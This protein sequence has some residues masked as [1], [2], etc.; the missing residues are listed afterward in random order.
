MAQSLDD[1][2]M[3]AGLVTQS[4]DDVTSSV[5]GGETVAPEVRVMERRKSQREGAAA[6]REVGG[7]KSFVV[8]KD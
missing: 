1:V 8:W 7:R 5:A 2:N 3:K 4:L 6:A